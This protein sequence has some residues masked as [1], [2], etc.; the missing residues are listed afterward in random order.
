[1]RLNGQGYYL[2]P[3][4]IDTRFWH[5]IPSI[6]E[7]RVTTYASPDATT[8]DGSIIDIKHGEPQVALHDAGSESSIEVPPLTVEERV[9]SVGP[10]VPEP[11]TYI[12]VETK[13]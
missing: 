3:G 6:P 13:Q 8:D 12:N 5:H 4:I 2:Q 10:S 9:P 1:V 7:A 11:L